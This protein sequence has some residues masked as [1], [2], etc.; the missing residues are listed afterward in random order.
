MRADIEAFLA[1]LKLERGLSPN[2]VSSYAH[3]LELFEQFAARHPRDCR[4]EELRSLL[5]IVEQVNDV[6]CHRAAIQFSR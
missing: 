5:G 2:T 4:T 3:D 1:H 6:P